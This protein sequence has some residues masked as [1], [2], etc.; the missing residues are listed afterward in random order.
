MKIGIVSV[1]NI[2][3]DSKRSASYRAQVL[4]ERGK[5]EAKINQLTKEIDADKAGLETVVRGSEAYLAES[6]AIVQKQAT[7]RA[8][9]DFYNQKTSLTEQK[10]TEQLYKD[11]LLAI[12]A[13]AKEQGLNMVFEKSEPELPASNPTQLELAMSTHKVLYCDGCSDITEEVMKRIDS[14]ASAETGS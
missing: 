6:W 10:I 12:S 4:A 5:T 7:L 9:R 2:F 11:I 1:R 8:E 3:R 13:V 14:M